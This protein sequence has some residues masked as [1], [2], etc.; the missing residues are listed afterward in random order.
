MKIQFTKEEIRVL[1]EIAQ[2]KITFTKTFLCDEKGKRIPYR[3]RFETW[4]DA[5]HNLTR[6]GFSH[7]D[8][9]KQ[10]GNKKK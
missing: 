4:D 5:Y 7:E 8:I 10:I 1:K 2:D 6:L 3:N 9:I